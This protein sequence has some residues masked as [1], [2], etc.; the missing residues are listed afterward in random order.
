MIRVHVARRWDLSWQLVVSCK[1]H[2]YVVREPA[3]FASSQEE[4]ERK[5]QPLAHAC[6]TM[7]YK[8]ATEL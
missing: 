6:T 3:E 1:S 2:E 5:W 4:A 8:R 7:L